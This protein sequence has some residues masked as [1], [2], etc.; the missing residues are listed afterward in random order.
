MTSPASADG[1]LFGWRDRVSWSPLQQYVVPFLCQ[2]ELQR[3]PVK[4][5]S[6]SLS[7][8]VSTGKPI[9]RTA[10]SMASMLAKGVSVGRLH[11]EATMSPLGFCPAWATHVRVALRTCSG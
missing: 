6:V 1:Q 8:S 4:G 5:L 10:S 11:P 3:L 7:F 2:T 9:S